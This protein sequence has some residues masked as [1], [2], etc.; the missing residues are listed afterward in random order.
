MQPRSRIHNDFADRT[1][2]QDFQAVQNVR[3]GKATD[4]ARFVFPSNA[5]EERMSPRRFGRV[6]H[7]H[8]TAARRDHHTIG[9]ADQG[10]AGRQCSSSVTSGAS[11]ELLP[12]YSHLV[13][14]SSA[15]R[16]WQVLFSGL[17]LTGNN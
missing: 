8:G 12:F 14:Q 3:E 6:K 13:R 16:A 4:A 1:A 9:K 5:D 17:A 7:R 2:K 10:A 15:P 11:L